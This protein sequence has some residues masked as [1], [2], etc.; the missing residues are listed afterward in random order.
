M[1]PR[2]WWYLYDVELQQQRAEKPQPGKLTSAEIARL[3]R[4]IE[5]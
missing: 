2:H 4:L 1:R 3:A 5:D